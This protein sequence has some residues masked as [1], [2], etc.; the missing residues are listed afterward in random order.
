MAGFD[1]P[2]SGICGIDEA[3]RGP[4]TGPVS[5][6][7]VILPEAFP[8]EILDDSKVLSQAGRERAYEVIVAGALDWAVG[9]AT[10]EE[11]GRI[12]I[13]AASLLAMKRAY[14]A[15]SLEPRIVIVDGNRIPQ[16]ERP[17]YALIKGDSILP[18]IM[19]ASILAKVARDRVMDRLD[20]IEPWFGFARNKGYPTKAHREAIKK[21]GLSLWARPGFR[22]G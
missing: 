15:L 1:F 20:S 13:L 17:A 19:A 22:I 9:W 4:L 14:C 8:I 5:A 7:A 6:G 2:V 16:L 21:T 18:S 10:W 11:I 3:G 12:N